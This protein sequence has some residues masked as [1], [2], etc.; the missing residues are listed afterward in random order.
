MQVLSTL[1]SRDH[2]WLVYTFQLSLP[3]GTAKTDVSPNLGNLLFVQER[4]ITNRKCRDSGDQGQFDRSGLLWEM[5]FGVG[6]VCSLTSEVLASF[7]RGV[8]PP[9]Y[10]DW[11]GWFKAGLP[12]FREDMPLRCNALILVVCLTDV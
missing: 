5:T 11:R 2:L 6:G 7:N 1:P 3:L 9:A 4:H 10:S 8:P 12:F